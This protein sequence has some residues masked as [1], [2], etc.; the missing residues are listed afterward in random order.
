MKY[1]LGFLLAAAL[2]CLGAPARAEQSGGNEARPGNAPPSK[3]TPPSPAPRKPVELS[4]KR[5]PPDYDGRGGPPTT[6][7][8]VLL[9]GPRLL[10]VPP[11][12]VSEY[13]I[14]RP[15]GWAIAGAERA[16]LPAYLYNF[17]T[18]GPDHNAGIFPTF[19]I[20]FGFYPSVGAFAFWNDA[21]AKGHDLRLR[22][23]TWGK[24]WLAASFAERYHIG[25]EPLDVIAL[26]GRYLKR[27]DY[28]FFGL[29]PDSRQSA[30]LRFGQTELEA[31]TYLR[32]Q[33]WRR[34]LVYGEVGIESNEFTPGGLADDP[35]LS[36]AI[37]TGSVPA[38]PGYDGYT[39]VRSSLLAT[40][41][42]RPTGA[43]PGSGV[44]VAAGVGHSSE[45]RHDT[46]FVR[47]GGSLAGF[48]DVND[49]KRVVSLALGARFTDPIARGEVPFTEQVTLGGDEPMRGFYEN[50]LIGESAVVAD[51]GYRWPIW[52]WLDGTMHAE[53]GNVFGPHLS[54]FSPGKL[55][56]SG[57]IGVEDT[58]P[59]DNR[60]QFLI[61]FGS[62]TFESGGKVSS[63]RFLFGTTYGF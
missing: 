46:T 1:K 44:R 35:L 10:L 12:F 62:E 36:D 56:F 6:A 29:G 48:L 16:G 17:F 22:G 38:P 42:S 57:A 8:D 14:R 40:L 5:T 4:E 9:W 25:K 54:G 21:F 43:R 19:F 47:Y 49:R 52:M 59:G 13:V 32:R 33:F 51:L 15:L 30:L 20:D 55:R 60:T 26:E 3:G 34:S 53:L 18:F 11:Y 28:T 7:G 39:V 24:N 2:A 27:P 37:R 58:N 61:G 45:L 50:R 23:A 31:K 63:F 41:D